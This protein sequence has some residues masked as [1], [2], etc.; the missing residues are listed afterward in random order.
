MNSNKII[1][2][3]IAFVMMIWGVQT[4]A[5]NDSHVGGMMI[6]RDL[7]MAWDFAELSRPQVFGTARS[8][9]MGGAFTSLGADLSSMSINPAGLGMYRHN[10]A[11]I[12]PILS[13]SNA[14]TAN[15]QSWGDNTKNRFS[16]ANFGIAMNL[17]ESGRSSVTGVTLGVGMNRIADFN[18]HFSYTDNHLAEP[19][20]RPAS[21]IADI[22]RNQL[23]YGAGGQPIVPER[24]EGGNPNG[25]LDFKDPYFWPAVLAY[26]SAM[27]HLNPFAPTPTWER[28]AIGQNAAIQRSVDGI[29]SGSINE[30]D[31]SVGANFNNKVYIG[32]TIGIQAISK[33]TEITYR[34]EYLY[35]GSGIGQ[36]AQGHNLQAQ[37]GFTDLWQRTEIEGSGIN[38]KLGVIVRPVDGLRLGFAFHTPTY[39]SLDRSYRAAMGYQLNDIEHGQIIERDPYVEKSP[40]QYDE[41]GNSWDFISPSRM[42]FGASYTFG[43]RAI[44]SVD[45]ERDWF[46]GIRVKKVP[47]GAYYSSSNYK[48]EIKHNF[49]ATN[50]VR[51]GLEVKPLQRL[52]L[53]VGGGYSSS[54]LK[55]ESLAYEMPQ[56]TTSYYITG[57]LGFKISPRVS[58]DVAYQYLNEEQSSYQLFY[59]DQRNPHT[60]AWETTSGSDFYNTSYQRHFV[61]MTLGVRF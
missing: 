23:Q 3:I 28:D 8:M 6:N 13:L 49:S 54:M 24:G 47:S 36:D 59:L 17:Y 41:G 40:T 60:G 61:S 26:K 25:R 18:T 1:Q 56:A 58:L 50:T 35:A 44:L 46:N 45:Y 27:V 16:I 43:Q 57:G 19:G 4:S 31:I 38:L 21:S 55:D 10:E 33:T 34:E 5:Q 15:T 12:T 7:M 51:A 39:Y 30:F 37:L 42:M 29:N 20:V 14:S 11:S 53:R 9:A 22:F 32:A 48:Q 52:A 2:A